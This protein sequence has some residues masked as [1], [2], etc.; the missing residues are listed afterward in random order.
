MIKLFSL[1]VALTICPKA[2]AVVDT[3]TGAF[4]HSW[5]DYEGKDLDLRIKFERTYNSRSNHKGWFGF[6]WCSDLETTIAVNEKSLVVN[7]CGDGIETTYDKKGSTYKTQQ[8]SDGVIRKDGSNY[9]RTFK[10]GTSEIFSQNGQL[11][12]IKKAQSY[13]ALKYN[14]KGIIK[15]LIDSG[16]RK[17][18]VTSNASGYVTAISF[19]A[20]QKSGTTAELEIA[21]YTYK[22]HDLISVKNAWGNVY[23]YIYDKEHNLTKAIWPNNKN[24]EIE[25]NANDWVKALKGTDICA[26][27]YDYKVDNAKNPPRYAV[28]IVKSCDKG[29]IIERSYAYTYSLDNRR[30]IAAEIDENGIRREYIYD[31]NGNVVEVIEHR[32]KGK[33]VTKIKR[34]DKGQIV[35]ISNPFEARSYFYKNGQGRDLVVEVVIEEIALGRVV[36]K[37]SY[38][39]AYDEDDRMISGIKPGGVSINFKYDDDNRLI[40][41]SSKGVSIDVIYDGDAREPKAVKQGDKELPLRIYEKA[42]TTQEIAAV[43]MYFDFVRLRE[44]AIPSY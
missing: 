18:Q 12:E 27:N 26:E 28:A 37:Y 15:E 16:G 21:L 34:N 29:Q 10:D 14:E 35:N 5:T 36:D 6:G 39:L 17:V 9:I 7:H 20:P 44:V 23:S 22:D 13:L 25:Y 43:E 30:V 4:T 19:Q 38:M 32:P 2:Y 24:I 40:K 11:T 8:A 41:V 33:V 31:N 1:F 3:A 42:A